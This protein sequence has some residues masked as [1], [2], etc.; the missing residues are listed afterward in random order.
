MKQLLML[1]AAIGL[2]GCSSVTL[3]PA[4]FS[5][6]VESIL[7]ADGNGMVSENRFAVAF[8]INELVKKEFKDNEQAT[9]AGATVRVIRD[10][11]GYYF[12]TAPKFKNVYVF[13]PGEGELKLHR[14]IEIGET[15]MADP[16]FN[17]RDTFIELLNNSSSVRLTKDGI[18][19]GDKK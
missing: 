4:D 10:R 11:Q 1:T 12:M 14:T 3:Q 19:E 18:L 5:W 16:K 2:F 7:K 8:S 17:Q 9:G 6:P 15:E 13:K